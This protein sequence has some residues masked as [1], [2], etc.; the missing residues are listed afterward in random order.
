MYVLLTAVV[1]KCVLFY[2]YYYNAAL[3]RASACCLLPTC[4]RYV[5]VSSVKTNEFALKNF[6]VLQV[7]TERN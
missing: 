6:N 4:V 7:T 2:V 5:C 1:L 3:L